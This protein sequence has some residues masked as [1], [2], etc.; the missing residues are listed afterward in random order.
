MAFIDEINLHLKA[1]RGG[2]GVVRWLHEKGKELGGPV[3]GNG[4]KGGDVYALGVRDIGILSAYKNVKE[5]VA[6]RGGDGEGKVR[7][8]AEGKDIEIKLPVGS[9]IR[10]LASGHIFE[11]LE[12]GEKIKLLAGGRGGLGNEHY[13]SSTNIRPKEFTL[14]EEGD[15]ADFEIELLMLVDVGLIGL[16]NAGKSTL[17]NTLTGAK[18]KVGAY[19]F[20]TLERSE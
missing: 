12:E 1:G 15:E 13:K 7:Q 5:F 17:L 8:G 14:G 3:G 20:T 10:N 6:G 18:S 16:P 11:L 19:Q 9:R 2:D 4:S